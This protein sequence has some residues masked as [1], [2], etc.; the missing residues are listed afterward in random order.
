M[1]LYDQILDFAIVAELLFLLYILLK[2]APKFQT[3]QHSRESLK[4][5]KELSRIK[6]DALSKL[7][8]LLDKRGKLQR[9]ISDAKK[10]YMKG[11]ITYEAMQ[12]LIEDATKRLIE[13]EEQLE[14]FEHIYRG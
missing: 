2:G 12:I 5:Q 10:R 14:D 1:A 4:K 9:F 3:R 7:N 11:E 13:L 6:E 8:V